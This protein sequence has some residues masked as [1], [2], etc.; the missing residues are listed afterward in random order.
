[1][2]SKLDANELLDVYGS[3][4][5]KRQQEILSLYYQEDL[6]YFEISEELSIS[7]AAVLDAVHRAMAQLEKY[8]QAI[9]YIKKRDEI[10]SLCQSVDENLAQQIERIYEQGGE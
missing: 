9:Q 1:M 7:R 2:K 10:L 5:T 8:E 4:L 6:S 3:L